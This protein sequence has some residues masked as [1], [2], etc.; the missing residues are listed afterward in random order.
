MTTRTGKV[1]RVVDSDTQFRLTKLA[2]DFLKNRSYPEDCPACIIGDD[3][4]YCCEHTDTIPTDACE[5]CW[6]R[7]DAA[8]I[9]ND[10]GEK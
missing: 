1:E 9:L 3:G 10:K 4:P 6:I 5:H 2:P 7:L 8:E